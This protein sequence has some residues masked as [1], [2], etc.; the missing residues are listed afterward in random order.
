M[1]RL[2][3]LLLMLTL[4]PCAALAETLEE[5]LAP[6]QEADYERLTPDEIPEGEITV[7][8][9]EAL[10]DAQD[11]RLFDSVLPLLIDRALLP[12]LPRSAY[13]NTG[14]TLWTECGEDFWD[15]MHAVMETPVEE[16][17]RYTHHLTPECDPAAIHTCTYFATYFFALETIFDPCPVCFP[18]GYQYNLSFTTGPD[19]CNKLRIAP[20]QTGDFDN[21][22]RADWIMVYFD[23]ETDRP[24]LIAANPGD[25]GFVII[26]QDKDMEPV[27]MVPFCP[28]CSDYQKD[29][30]DLFQS[31]ILCGNCGELV[32]LTAE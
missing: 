26:Q 1:K 3:S 19:G 31:L 4:L 30:K 13:L 12:E 2:I 28:E 11:A 5:R 7:D 29:F 20:W 8:L 10:N 27:R 22:M 24:F 14:A 23:H 32:R 17:Q 9:L 15:L 16:M 18:A 6:F 21:Q 25:K